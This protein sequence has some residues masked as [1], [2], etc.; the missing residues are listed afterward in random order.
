MK[1][2]CLCMCVGVGVG[3]GAP[4]PCVGRGTFPP[5]RAEWDYKRAAAAPAG[6]KH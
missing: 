4:A 6:S 3:V 5:V 2:N 1:Y